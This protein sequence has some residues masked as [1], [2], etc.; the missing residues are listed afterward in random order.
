VIG[1]TN[2]HEPHPRGFLHAGYIA[3]G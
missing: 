3:T 2:S 1:D